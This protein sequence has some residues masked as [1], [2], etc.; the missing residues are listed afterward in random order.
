MTIHINDLFQCSCTEVPDVIPQA[1]L[2]HKTVSAEEISMPHVMQQLPTPKRKF[3]EPLVPV[4]Q[5]ADILMAS[6]PTAQEITQIR[7][8]FNIN[9]DSGLMATGTVKPWACTQGGNESSVMLTVYNMF[10]LLKNIPLTQPLVWAPSYTNVYDW[11]RSLT[12]TCITFHNDI[13]FASF[14]NRR[15]WIDGRN[16]DDPYYRTSMLALAAGILVH[17]A[18]HVETQRGHDSQTKPGGDTDM[19]GAYGAT[20]LYAEMCANN[21]GTFFTSY[22][23]NEFRNWAASMRSFYIG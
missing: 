16:R 19:G 18:R 22:Q 17:E 7:H 9:F 11:L 10:R 4:Y 6:C 20:I 13:S 3:P 21:S 5:T 1:I 2:W 23:Q 15:I 8:D 14:T 12:L